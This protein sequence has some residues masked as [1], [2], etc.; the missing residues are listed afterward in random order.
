MINDGK[1]AEVSQ[2]YEELAY[3]DGADGFYQ[4]LSCNEGFFLN[5]DGEEM[6]G[7]YQNQKDVVLLLLNIMNEKQKK[8]YARYDELGNLIS[9]W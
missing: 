3:L 2:K 7:P 8:W 1:I 4:Y 9:K 6:F 5:I